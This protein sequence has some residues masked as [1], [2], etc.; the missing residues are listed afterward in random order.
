M[1]S[2]KYGTKKLRK[3]TIPWNVNLIFVR[4]NSGEE[5]RKDGQTDDYLAG[6][7]LR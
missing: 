1:W 5:K 3:N 7:S 6:N 4:R 2:L